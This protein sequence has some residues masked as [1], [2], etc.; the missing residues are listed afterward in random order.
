MTELKL[1]LNINRTQ[2]IF[3][4]YRPYHFTSRP[5]VKIAVKFLGVTIHLGLIA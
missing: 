2:E 5:T 3:V 1:A 4:V